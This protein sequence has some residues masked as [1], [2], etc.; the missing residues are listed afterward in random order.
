VR[1][2]KRRK[3]FPDAEIE[4]SHKESFNANRKTERY[5]AEKLSGHWR[6]NSTPGE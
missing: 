6:Y 3:A 5:G 4:T 2:T 1:I